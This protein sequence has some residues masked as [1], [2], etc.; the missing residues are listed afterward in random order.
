M[1]VVAFSALLLGEKVGPR[2]WAAVIAG[3][4]G[5]LLIVRP[6]F[7]K[8]EPPILIA[9][10]AA[11]LWAT[12]QILLRYS[13]RFDRSETTTLWTALV[14]LAATTLVGPAVWVWPDAFGWMVLAAIALLGTAAHIFMI[15]ALVTTEA[16]LLQPYSYTLF[17][18]AVVVGYLFFGDIPDH[19]TLAGAGI[20]ILSGIYIW[21]RE[22]IRAREAPAQKV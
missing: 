15:R 21:H 5:V 18:W 16:G 1:L 22:R 7:E 6:G 9:L 3:F 4:V 11:A 13:A 14:G 12:Y 8:I 20:I 19:W 17:I 10:F 2:R